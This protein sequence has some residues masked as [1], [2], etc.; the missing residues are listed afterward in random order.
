MRLKRLDKVMLVLLLL[1]GFFACGLLLLCCFSAGLAER[2]VGLVFAVLARD[3]V[4][5]RIIA[6]VL[7]AVV[8]FFIVRI[9]FVR[10]KRLVDPA[11]A[12]NSQTP[13]EQRILI[14][15]GEH[16]Q[17]FITPEAVRDMALR[18]L[19]S[20]PG[21]RDGKVML[22]VQDENGNVGVQLE[23]LPMADANL[24][25]LSTALQQEI[26]SGIEEKTGIAISQVQ[27]LIVS[28]EPTV[29]AEKEKPK[30]TS[31]R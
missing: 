29:L 27:V 20:N 7:L 10:Q 5:N 22:D 24:P 17:S 2:V 13:P 4:Y 25:A 30:R 19:Q 1:V 8:M 15:N 9:L 14:K 23:V 26:K 3:P 16:G 28:E 6:G 18:L 12:L 21:V 11:L 31:V